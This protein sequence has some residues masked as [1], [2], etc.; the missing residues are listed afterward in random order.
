MEVLLTQPKVELNQQVGND[1]LSGFEE[2]FYSNV[3]GCNW[4][5]QNCF[6]PNF[7][8]TFVLLSQ[9]KL[10]DTALHAAAWKGYEDIVEILLGKGTVF[11]NIP[12]FWVS[13]YQEICVLKYNLC[14]HN[15]T[16]LS[17][18]LS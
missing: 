2:L 18:N 9:N 7:K 15:D 14:P 17:L 3:A 6:L 12:T 13:V 8:I 10:G 16:S 1:T 11:L 4:N 5:D